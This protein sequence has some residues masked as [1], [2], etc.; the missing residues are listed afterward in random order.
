MKDLEPDRRMF[1]GSRVSNATSKGRGEALPHVAELEH[2][3]G[4]GPANTGIANERTTNLRVTLRHR[5]LK[6]AT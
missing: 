4:V 3:A 6:A 5:C 1:G 2:R